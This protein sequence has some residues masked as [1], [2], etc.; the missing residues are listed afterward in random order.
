MKTIGFIGA[1]VMGKS[2]AHNLLKAGFAL[3]VYTRT[4][5]KAADLLEEGAH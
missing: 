5:E 3:N 2:M 1:G 4:K